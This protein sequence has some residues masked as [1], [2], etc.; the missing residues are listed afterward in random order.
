VPKIK[1]YDG[2]MIGVDKA[3][4][5]KIKVQAAKKGQSIKEYIKSLVDK[6]GKKG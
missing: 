4:H 1:D 3:T 2:K 6:E 5:K